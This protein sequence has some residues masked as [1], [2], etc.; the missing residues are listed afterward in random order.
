MRAFMM[1]IC[2]MVVLATPAF[3][4]RTEFRDKNGNP[5]GY[6][7]HEENRSVLRDNSGNPHGHWQQEGSWLVHRDNSGN[8]LDRQQTK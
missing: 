1:V 6:I 3:A 5:H 7:Q 8:L 2:A 4:Q